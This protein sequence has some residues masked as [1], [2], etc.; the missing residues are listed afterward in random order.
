[1]PLDKWAKLGKDN[2][3]K[4]IYSNKTYMGKSSVS[5]VARKML[6]KITEMSF[7]DY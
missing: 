7:Y 3:Q 2:L 1:M 6:I 4:G 5:L